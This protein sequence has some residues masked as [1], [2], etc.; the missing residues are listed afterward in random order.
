MSRIMSK[1]SADES[2]LLDLTVLLPALLI[3]LLSKEGGYR[4]L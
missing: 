4:G 2:H 1:S 3:R